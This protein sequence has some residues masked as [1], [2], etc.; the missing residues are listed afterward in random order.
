[1]TMHL[2]VGLRAVLLAMAG[3]LLPQVVAAGDIAVSAAWARATPPGTVMGA[4][5]MVIDNR[6]Q[7]PDRLLGASSPRA[8]AVEVHAVVRDGTTMRMRRAEPLVLGPGERVTLA[9]GGLHAMLVNLDAPLRA[10]EALP[11]TL[12][13]ERAGE[14]QVEAA[15]VAAD[16]PPP[17]AA[18]R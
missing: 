12:R 1:M 18:G 3:M 14:L 9:P 2:H 16:A 11:L 4:A 8:A 15:V 6:G 17:R 10:G 7:K 5:Y 13:F